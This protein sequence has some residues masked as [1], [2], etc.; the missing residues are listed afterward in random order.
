MEASIRLDKDGTP[1]LVILQES[2]EG[3]EVNA[4]EDA[5]SLFFRK[6]INSGGGSLHL[7]ASRDKRAKV[8]VLAGTGKRFASP[9]EKSVLNLTDD[10]GR[11]EYKDLPPDT[12]E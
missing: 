12:A 4:N 1:Y 8:I 10:S 7:V 5:E 2:Q 11:K 9:L 6:L 3:N